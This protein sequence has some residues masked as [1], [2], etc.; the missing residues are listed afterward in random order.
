MAMFTKKGLTDLAKAGAVAVGAVAIAEAFGI[1]S[2][3]RGIA[4]KLR[5]MVTGSNQTAA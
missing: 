4:A 2:A 1:M 5:S 3:V